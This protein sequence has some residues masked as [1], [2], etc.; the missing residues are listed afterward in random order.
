MTGRSKR[1]LRDRLGQLEGDVVEH[2]DAIP[3]VALS[4]DII[5][6]EDRDRVPDLSNELRED[7]KLALLREREAVGWG[8]GVPLLTLEDVAE[9]R[10]RLSSA[11]ADLEDDTGVTIDTSS[12]VKYIAGRTRGEIAADAPGVTAHFGEDVTP[13]HATRV[14]R[15]TYAR[16]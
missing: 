15:E 14:C 9:F 7:Y 1:D 11:L 5:R 12:F 2:E 16:A 3:L 13:D 6:P 4:P 10:D 8:R